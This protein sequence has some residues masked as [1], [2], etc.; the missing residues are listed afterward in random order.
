[1]LSTN[2][3]TLAS[4]LGRLDIKIKDRFGNALIRREWFLVTL[5]VIDNAVEKIKDGT[6]TGYVYDPNS[7]R[8]VRRGTS[9]LPGAVA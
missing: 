3:S 8:L 2:V 5:F 9:S 4:L 7:A 1:M 6:I